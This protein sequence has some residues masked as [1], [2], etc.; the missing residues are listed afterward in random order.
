M[1]ICT[2]HMICGTSCPKFSP[3][4]SHFAKKKKMAPISA[5]PFDKGI[6]PRYNIIITT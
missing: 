1:S 4:T 2:K 6:F 3:K 5:A